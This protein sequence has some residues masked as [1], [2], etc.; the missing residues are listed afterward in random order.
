MGKTKLLTIALDVQ[1][2][3]SG[4]L[5][6]GVCGGEGGLVREESAVNVL[7]L[8]RNSMQG[9][10][11]RHIGKYDVIGYTRVS[12]GVCGTDACEDVTAVDTTGAQTCGAVCVE[13]SGC[14][15][16]GTTVLTTVG[17][18]GEERSISMQQHRYLSLGRGLLAQTDW[19][20]E[21]RGIWNLTALLQLYSGWDSPDG[22]RP[23]LRQPAM[24][25]MIASLSGVRGTLIPKDLTG[26][27]FFPRLANTTT[28]WPQL[29]AGVVCMDPIQSFVRD[30][31]LCLGMPASKQFFESAT[32]VGRRFFGK[33]NAFAMTS[34]W[35]KWRVFTLALVTPPINA[36]PAIFQRSPYERASM[37]PA[38]E[39]LAAYGLREVHSASPNER[40]VAA[41]IRR[42]L[43]YLPSRR[44]EFVTSPESSYHLMA[45]RLHD[46]AQKDI[47]RLSSAYDRSTFDVDEP[48]EPAT[49]QD[50]VLAV[51]VILPEATAMV[52]ALL[53]TRTWG[54]R[55]CVAVGMI[56]AV[57][58]ASLSALISLAVTER[59]GADWRVSSERTALGARFP[60]GIDNTT[61]ADVRSVLTGTELAYAETYLIAARTGYHP[62]L[63]LWL[64]VGF[65]AA[66]VVVSAGSAAYIVRAWRREAAAAAARWRR[67]SPRP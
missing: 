45:T 34:G 9:G 65:F 58:L 43:L 6:W 14:S 60:V 32:L 39:P 25:R 28:T 26:D 42:R 63:L 44:G 22:K 46:S 13:G 49:A 66:Y 27:G 47:E 57:G 51:L 21:H 24:A 56:F 54:R 50:V 37:G 38:V 8:L 20:G 7:T 3:P 40:A 23:Q 4:P 55:E 30:R 35:A 67:C 36:T 33:G 17:P 52:V 62:T 53:A 29:L 10:V 5:R 15:C 12:A 18:D 61:F 31:T 41:S 48:P 16:Q 2:R 64:A 19:L 11:A 59:R 1:Y